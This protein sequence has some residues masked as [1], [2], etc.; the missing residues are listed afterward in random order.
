MHTKT[1]ASTLSVLIPNIFLLLWTAIYPLIPDSA[2]KNIGYHLFTTP[3]FFMAIVLATILCHFP[4]LS[5]SFIMQ[6][7]NPSDIQIIQEMESV[8]GVVKIGDEYSEYYT[9]A[10]SLVKRISSGS[11][12]IKSP[13]NEEDEVSMEYLPPPFIIEKRRSEAEKSSTTSMQS[14]I[15][16][17]KV[18]DKKPAENLKVH[19]DT[20]KV[21]ITQPTFQQQISY[22]EDGRSQH[23]ATDSGERKS[24]IHLNVMTKGMDLDQ[25]GFSFSESPGV[26]DLILGRKDVRSSPL[27]MPELHPEVV[28]SRSSL[29]ST[30]SAQSVPNTTRFRPRANTFTYGKRAR[31]SMS[32]VGMLSERDLDLGGK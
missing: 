6:V 23:S 25:R 18:P 26:R 9:P 8:G 19:F 29:T 11:L 20:P 5:M 14:E 31:F 30:Q 16:E 2:L 28:D 4:R 27:R 21:N 24:S 7:S 10:E 15:L 12:Y 32:N 1:F 3:S 22:S 17:I 13:A